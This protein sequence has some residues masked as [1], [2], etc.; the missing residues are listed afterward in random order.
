MKTMQLNK[1]GVTLVELLAVIVIMGII[2]AIAVP[3]ISGLINRQR[4]NAAEA[5]YDLIAEVAVNYAQAEA[6]NEVTIAELVTAGYLE[7]NPFLEDATLTIS[8]TTVTFAVEG[9]ATTFTTLDG[10]VSV[11]EAGVASLVP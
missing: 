1:R 9:A 6:D 2:A 5:S 10:K 4:M 8:G 3:A 7:S 11:T